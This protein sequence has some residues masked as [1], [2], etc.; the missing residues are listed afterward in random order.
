MDVMEAS[1]NLPSFHGLCVAVSH[2]IS[3]SGLST[4][5]SMAAAMTYTEIANYYIPFTNPY[6]EAILGLAA[7]PTLV[8]T[9]DGAALGYA[10]KVYDST[11]GVTAVTPETL[12]NFTTGH[13][14]ST[15][16]SNGMVV[17]DGGDIFGH[18]FENDLMTLCKRPIESKA[19]FASRSD[20]TYIDMI[21]A[22]YSATGV[23]YRDPKLSSAESSKFEIGQSQ[24]L[25]YS[26]DIYKMINGLPPT[27]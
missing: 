27:K 12:F 7:N 16:M 5:V 26:Q 10:N 14:R 25:D 9:D 6:L 8:N 2:N 4:Q 22:N 23:K 19:Q 13:A 3:A 11:L 21:A 18:S 15:K 24:F 17:G 1:P 20:A